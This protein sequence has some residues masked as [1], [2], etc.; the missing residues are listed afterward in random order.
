MKKLFRALLYI[1]AGLI[2]LVGLVGGYVSFFLPNVGKAADLKLSATPERL[3]RGKYLAMNVAVCIDCHSTRDWTKFAGPFIPGTEGQGGEKF[4]KDLGFPGT[5]YAKNITPAGIGAWTDGEFLRA[6]TSG[7]SKDGKALFALMPYQHYGVAD[8]EDILSI[9]AY[10]RSLPAIKNDVPPSKADFPVN[11]LMN[12]APAKPAFIT[13]PVESDTVKYGEYLVNMSSCLTC[14]SKENKGDII[15]GT[16]FGGGREFVLPSGT[17]RSMNITMHN[18]GISYMN[19]EQ[20]IQRFKAYSDTSYRSPKIG[21]TDFNTVMPW[22]MYAGMK[23][24]DLAAIYAFLKTVKP[25]DNKVEKFTTK[26]M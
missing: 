25:I 14:H 24:S 15:K 6:V 18:T 17:V 10:I 23:T 2:V 20:F 12:L 7:V 4:G 1:V 5:F 8:K 19:Q 26:K 22:V 16:E 11:I 13:K 9:M 3:E 21:P